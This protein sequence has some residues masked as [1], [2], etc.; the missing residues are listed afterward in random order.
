MAG[1]LP[2]LLPTSDPRDLVEVQDTT[3]S[4]DVSGRYVCSTWEEATNNGGL[5]FD[6]VVIG[7]GMFGAYAAEKIY[8]NSNLRVLVL[9]AGS[10]LVS[11]HVQNLARIGLNVAGAVRVPS[12]ANDPGTRERVWGVPW[13]SQVAFPGLAYAVG[14]RSL[15]WG[16]WAPRLTPADLA[17]HWPP[18]VAG[19]LQSPTQKDDEYERTEKETGVFDKTD[20]ISG[21]LYE[22]LKKRFTAV[23]ASG[24]PGVS[25]VDAIEEAPLAVQGAAPASGL[26]SFDK[27]SSAPILADAIREATGSPD[28][29][30][31]LFL[32]PRA[33]VTR[34]VSM[35]QD[36]TRLELFVNGQQKFLDVQ[37]SCAIILAN[38][39][40]ESTRLA[41]E[42]FETA[43]MGRNLM[44]HLRSNTT[45]RIKRA[46]FDPSLPQRVEAAALL[47]RGSA[48]QRRFHIQVTAAAVAGADPE[49]VMFHMIPDIDLVDRMLSSEQA[50]SIVLTFRGI[51]EMEPARNADA[52]KV[53]GIAPSWLDLSDQ[54]D[55]FGLRRAWVNLVPTAKDLELWRTMDDTAVAFAQA[56]AGVPEN[57][58]YFYN[59][60]ASLNASGAAWHSEPPPPSSSSDRNG[61]ANKVRDGLGTTHHEAGTLWMGADPSTSVTDLN[62]RFHHRSNVYV[63]GPALFPALGSA[64]PSLTALTLARRTTD[65]IVERSF[66]LQPGFHRLGN[67][68]LNGWRMAGSGGFIE[69]GAN[70]IESAGG[71]GLLWFTEE[72]FDNFVLHVEWRASDITDN[73]G[74]FIRFPTLGNADPAND[75]KLAVDQGYEIQIDDRGINPDAGT[76]H[77]P[78]HQTGA[79]YGIAAA[80]HLASKPVGQWNTFEIEARGQD[81]RVRLNG[82]M[83]SQLTA[84]GSRPAKGHIG[85]QN[86][87]PGARVQFRN[88]QIEPLGV[89]AP[90]GA[91]STGGGVARGRS[92]VRG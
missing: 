41:I 85:L 70:I 55:E 3:F 40:I 64:N 10:Y 9:E 91:P 8:R 18:E 23:Q 47:V 25:K 28:W 52:T 73:S 13:R 15:Y 76:Q 92:R 63:A 21:P 82:D 81:I 66:H 54:R 16:G 43:L 33:H 89:S 62:G 60:D 58:E 90:A 77:D 45:V 34:L 80:S 50:D 48:S 7:A 19:S 24:A 51:G 78:L 31:R 71:I 35:G 61:P 59:K 74:I 83:V 88:L 56:L 49:V 29:Q 4:V 57:I 79:I 68:S 38:G 53:T 27:Y 42:S 75:W 72:V 44:A 6:V 84:D 46:A 17:E 30:R 39:T 12:N 87:H 69:L 37:P 5:P 22:E 36:V 11:E 1:N 26:F 32:V 20:Y 65:A 86:H 67:G 14:G 2:R